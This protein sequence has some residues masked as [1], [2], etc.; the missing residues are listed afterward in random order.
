MKELF[1]AASVVARLKSYGDQ[2]HRP[3][4]VRRYPVGQK[5][6]HNH[7]GEMSMW[8]MS[9]TEKGLKGCQLRARR[10][11]FYMSDGSG[12]HKGSVP[13][14]CISDIHD[15]A[16]CRSLTCLLIDILAASNVQYYFRICI[17][18]IPRT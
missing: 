14:D 4:F 7:R 8:R 6:M 12:G 3:T 16:S 13:M 9:D 1:L 10:S 11:N 17:D 5:M 15:E 18:R 2:T